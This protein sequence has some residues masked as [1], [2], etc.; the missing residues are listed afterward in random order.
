[1]IPEN[2]NTTKIF[3][4]NG[5]IQTKIK[6][7]P[8]R[9]IDYGTDSSKRYRIPPNSLGLK[10]LAN[11]IQDKQINIKNNRVS[12]PSLHEGFRSLQTNKN[13]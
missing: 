2:W 11:T 3:L 10:I 13:N 12:N 5:G 6:Q 7:G 9:T 8:T 1:M 4:H